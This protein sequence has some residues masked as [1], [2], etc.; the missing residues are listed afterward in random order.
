MTE[1]WPCPCCGFRTLTEGPG[2]YDLCRVCFWEDDPV[3]LRWPWC[4]EG[5]NGIALIAAQRSFARIGACSSGYLDR[6]RAARADEPK[7]QGWRPLDPEIDDFERSM[8]P[9]GRSPWPENDEALYW[10]R[11]TY[12]RR[13]ENRVSVP[14]PRRKPSNPAERLMA[15]ILQAVPEAEPVDLAVR[16]RYEAPAP[17]RFCDDLGQWVLDAYTRGDTELARRAVEVVNTGLT[18]EDGFAWNC[19]GVA[20]LE[21]EGWRDPNLAAEI[22]AWPDEIRV[23]LGRSWRTGPPSLADRSSPTSSAM[24]RR[25][26]SPS[27]LVVGQ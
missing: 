14:V 7:E 24:V 13:P 25:P 27:A 17:F 8:D 3:A 4:D 15:R 12:F 22:A 21:H 11:P 16:T 2:D 10:W 26:P 6:S 1:K 5:P 20:F 18:D 23:E 19:V 9:P